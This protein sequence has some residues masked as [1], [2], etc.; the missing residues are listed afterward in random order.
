MRFG[1]ATSS[2]ALYGCMTA[3]ALQGL[4][5]LV[6]LVKTFTAFDL[7]SLFSLLI[8]FILAAAAF[9]GSWKLR[10]ST[11]FSYFV[12][13]VTAGLFLIAAGLIGM[14]TIGL[15]LLPGGVAIVLTALVLLMSGDDKVPW[16]RG[17]GI[18]VCSG[19]FIIMLAAQ[20]YGVIYLIHGPLSKSKTPNILTQSIAH[21]NNFQAF[22]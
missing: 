22:D 8:L 6:L 3:A 7:S 17:F 14:A 11:E 4:A 2:L 19:L 13:V 18:V 5:L 12:L 15:F 16:W 20:L 1:P 9:F 21:R 10:R